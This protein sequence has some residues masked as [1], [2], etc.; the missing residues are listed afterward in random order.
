MCVGISSMDP[1]EPGQWLVKWSAGAL[2]RVEDNMIQKNVLL[3]QFFVGAA[4][5]AQ[6]SFHL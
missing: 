1:R 3:P 2:C 6:Y 4:T 5:T